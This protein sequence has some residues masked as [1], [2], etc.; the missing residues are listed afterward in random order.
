MGGSNL[1]GGDGP[2]SQREGPKCLNEEV[3]QD[4]S[5]VPGLSFD[6]VDSVVDCS[7]GH[8][9]VESWLR[10]WNGRFT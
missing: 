4:A 6:R 9:K 2:L 5:L 1:L 8:R 3:G 10:V 7:A